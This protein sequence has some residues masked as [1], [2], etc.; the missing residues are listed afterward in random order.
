MVK[1]QI[2]VKTTRVYIVIFILSPL[3]R[4]D[5]VLKM[6]SKRYSGV[7]TWPKLINFDNNKAT[8]L[9]LAVVNSG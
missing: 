2:R 8:N 9:G 7:P 1:T 4:F 6:C 5:L 3:F